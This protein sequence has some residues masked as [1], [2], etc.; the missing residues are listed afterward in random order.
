MT[1]NRIRRRLRLTQKVLAER[2]GISSNTL[3]RHER[4]ELPIREPL[5]RLILCVAHLAEQGDDY[6]E[7][8]A[9]IRRRR[10]R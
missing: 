3:A 8:L 4:N 1:L 6:P 10:R 2:L 7:Y 9:L 5:A